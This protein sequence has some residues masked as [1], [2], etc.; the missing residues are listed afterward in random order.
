MV[1][2]QATINLSQFRSNILAIRKSLDPKTRL[3]IVI[4]ADAY[5]LSATKLAPIAQSA[6]VDFLAVATT[7]EAIE[8]RDQGI[9][10]PILLLSEPS[11]DSEWMQIVQHAITPTLY[12]FHAAEAAAKV[13]AE[14][15]QTISYHLKIDTGMARLGIS[16]RSNYSDFIHRLNELGRLLLV[17]LYTHFSHSDERDAIKISRQLSDFNQVCHC[18][19]SEISHPLICHAANSYGAYFFPS[20][21]LDMVR[22]GLL[23]YDHVVSI[24]SKLN[25]IKAVRKGD[26]VGYGGQFVAGE[27][28]HLGI[29]NAGYADGIPSLLSNGGR[30]LIDGRFF[31]VVGR[32][33]M[34][35]TF[36]DLGACPNLI[37]SGDEVVFFGYQGDQYLSLISECQRIGINAREA[38]CHLGTRIERD[39]VFNDD[40]VVASSFGTLQSVFM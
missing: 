38:M 19:Q 7:T 26:E 36:V 9:S 14:L 13:C 28:T 23:S 6:G 17:G 39:Y 11:T 21:H 27:D 16:H 12:T 35:L 25:L 33:C 37:G 40:G 18:I 10:I 24:K 30:V 5:G 20:S 32:V 31:P 15:N 8:L 34:D 1:R 29:V 3:M 4:K 2:A 22:I